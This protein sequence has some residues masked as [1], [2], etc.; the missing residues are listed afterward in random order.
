MLPIKYPHDICAVCLQP[1]KQLCSRCK[2]IYYCSTDCQKKDWKTHKPCCGTDQAP[3]STR[4]LVEKLTPLLSRCDIETNYSRVMIGD[5]TLARTLV[6]V[7]QTDNRG[8]VSV[9]VVGLAK[10]QKATNLKQRRNEAE[11]AKFRHLA[12]RAMDEIEKDSIVLLFQ[13]G[14]SVLAL[15]Y[16]LTRKCLVAV[17]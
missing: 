16:S 1:A 13:D 11:L 8:G 17:F 10:R 6:L 4:L 14:T 2:H 12:R 7:H 5:R 15:E 3:E 9:S